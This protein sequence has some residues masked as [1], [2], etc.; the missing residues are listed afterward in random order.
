MVFAAL[1]LS[2]VKIHYFLKVFKQPLVSFGPASKVICGIE[3]NRS[4]PQMLV[5]L[6][7]ISI[8]CSA[9]ALTHFRRMVFPSMLVSVCKIGK[10]CTSLINHESVK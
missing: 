9:K 8:S 1:N 3:T 2:T 7:L 6:S 4:C 10:Y 5:Q